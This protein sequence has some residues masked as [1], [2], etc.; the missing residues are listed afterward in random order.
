MTVW[1]A[2]GYGPGNES[3]SDALVQDSLRVRE[4]GQQNHI[5]RLI[6]AEWPA[7]ELDAWHMAA[8]TNRLC[9]TNGVYRGPAGTTFVFFTLGKIQMSKRGHTTS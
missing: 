7:K 3:L 8:L 6:S 9:E 5:Q 1:Q 2:H 4:F